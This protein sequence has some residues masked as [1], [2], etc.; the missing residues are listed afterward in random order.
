M[1]AALYPALLI[2]GGGFIAKQLNNKGGSDSQC[3][4]YPSLRSV[5]V[6]LRL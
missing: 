2:A 3:N 5:P 4:G 6:V 1:T